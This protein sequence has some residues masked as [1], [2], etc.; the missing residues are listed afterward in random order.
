M[1]H[2]TEFSWLLK[3]LEHSMIENQLT[4]IS[5][6]MNGLEIRLQKK[7][8]DYTAKTQNQA[9]QEPEIYTSVLSPTIGTF[10]AKPSPSDKPFVTVSSHVKKGQVLGLIE[11]MKVFHPIYSP[12]DGKIINIIIQDG[13]S[14][15]YEQCLMQIEH[16][17]TN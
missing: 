8:L 9:P 6:S 14:A 7:N 1:T 11:S 10:Y 13:H 4:E 5:G 16:E 15:E 12:C 17:N 3:T 2:K